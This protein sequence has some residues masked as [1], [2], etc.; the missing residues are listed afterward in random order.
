M[1]HCLDKPNGMALRAAN[2][3]AHLAH[4]EAHERHIIAAG[5]LLSEDGQAMRGSL[6]LMDFPDRAAAEKFAA[7]DPYAK[8]GL[9]AATTV[10]PWRQVYPKR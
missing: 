7:G 2:R 1:I 6:L 4:L 10:A 8:A 3:A 9:F 5:P